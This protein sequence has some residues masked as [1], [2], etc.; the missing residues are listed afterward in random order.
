MGGWGYPK[1]PLSQP[2][3]DKDDKMKKKKGKLITEPW[4]Y[5]VRV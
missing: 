2:R 4:I 1:S 3:R 5:D